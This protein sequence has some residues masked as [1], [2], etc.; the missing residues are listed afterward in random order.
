MV[1]THP[2]P[3]VALNAIAE[4]VGRFFPLIGGGWD[5]P[6]QVPK[7]DQTYQVWFLPADAIAAGT[8]DFLAR[9]QNTERWHCQIWWDSKPMFVARFIVRNGDTSDLELRQVLI[10]EYAN[11]IDEAIRWVDTNVE[12][13]PL[14]RIL[15]IPSCY[16]TALWL[17][18]GDENRLVIARLPPGPQ[19]LKRLEVYSARA[20]LTKVRQKR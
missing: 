17:I 10:N 14:I 11:S 3:E 5:P 8:T 19:V 1:Q 18:D 12:G 15:D 2:I 6:R 4:Q 16:I 9:A 13:N 7:P 20:F